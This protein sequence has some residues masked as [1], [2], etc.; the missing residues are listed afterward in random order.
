LII[1]FFK[2]TTQLALILLVQLIIV[3]NIE[4]HPYINPFI[5]IVFI[6]AL[7]FKLKPWIV[8]VISF[9]TGALVDTFTTTPGLHMA[10]TTLMG[11]VRGFYLKF[12][13]GKEDFQGKANPGIASKGFIWFFIYS[14]FLVF[15][16][17]TALFFLEIYGFSEF[18]STMLRIFASTLMSVALIL[19]G[20][21]VFYRNKE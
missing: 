9:L 19:L 3:S 5:Y 11:Y 18:F 4:I 6:L 21:M 7:P 2:Y 1:D 10:A 20:Q 12:A 13:A 17:H 8:V 14:L 15:V 16:H